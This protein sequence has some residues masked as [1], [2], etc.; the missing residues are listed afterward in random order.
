[1]RGLSLRGMFAA[2]A[3]VALLGT[4]ALA[5]RFGVATCR[6][7]SQAAADRTT[8]TVATGEI[9]K[10]NAELQRTQ[11]IGATVET[12]RRKVEKHF[13]RIQKD[14]ARMARSD[15]DRCVLP[16]DRLRQWREAN[17]GPGGDGEGAAFTEPDHAGGAAAATR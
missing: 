11:V 7:E 12:Q 17:A 8:A 2:L 9:R 1:M 6:L 16:A 5:Y 14:S 13:E 15:I 4:H 10:G 3:C